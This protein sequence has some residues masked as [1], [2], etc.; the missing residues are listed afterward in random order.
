MMNILITARSCY[1]V[2]KLQPWYISDLKF[3]SNHAKLHFYV[4]FCMNEQLFPLLIFTFSGIRKIR[5]IYQADDFF[6]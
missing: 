2:A 5:K 6:N 3:H 4:A 1:H